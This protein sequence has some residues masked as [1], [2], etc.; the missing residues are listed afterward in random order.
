MKP[1]ETDLCPD[2]TWKWPVHKNLSKAILTFED[3]SVKCL[4]DV[5]AGKAN[6]EHVGSQAARTK[7]GAM[8]QFQLGRRSKQARR[9]ARA[10][11]CMP[12]RRKVG[13]PFYRRSGPICKF[14]G[15]NCPEVSVWICDVSGKC[16][17]WTVQP[18]MW[19]RQWMTTPIGTVVSKMIM[20]HLVCTVLVKQPIR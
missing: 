10:P 11:F 17:P 15:G 1:S 18:D 2:L 13:A 4:S 8:N 3:S 20:E 16:A 19:I 5:L 6:K 14:C 12:V 9:T 7:D